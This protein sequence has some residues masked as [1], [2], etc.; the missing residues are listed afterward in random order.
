MSLDTPKFV[1]RP[2]GATQRLPGDALPL[3]LAFDYVNDPFFGK[4]I[5]FAVCRG[6]GVGWPY[7]IVGVY[8][9]DWR[10][11][12]DGAVVDSDVGDVS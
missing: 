3:P 12:Y 11:T 2:A 8:D 5:A 9:A 6:S 4:P 10:L 7:D 1:M